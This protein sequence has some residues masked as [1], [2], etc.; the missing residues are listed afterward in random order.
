MG[1][2]RQIQNNAFSRVIPLCGFWTPNTAEQDV[3]GHL[4]FQVKPAKRLVS[5]PSQ[6]IDD[7]NYQ[8]VAA[9]LNQLH[10]APVFP[11]MEGCHCDV[12]NHD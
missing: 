3:F 9:P 8:V 1:S 12:W 11:K 7:G 4:I 2:L 5:R 10:S 6:F